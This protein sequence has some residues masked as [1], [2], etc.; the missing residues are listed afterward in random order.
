MSQ[1]EDPQLQ[2]AAQREYE[3]IASKV[4]AALSMLEDVGFDATMFMGTWV[5]ELGQTARIRKGTG[6]WYAQTGMMAEMMERRAAQTNI[7][8]MHEAENDE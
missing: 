7:E 2:S 1:E 4:D 6:N 5:N 3:R 8:V